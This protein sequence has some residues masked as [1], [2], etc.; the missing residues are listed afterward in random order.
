M[1]PPPTNIVTAVRAELAVPGRYHLMSPRAEHQS[2][3]GRILQWLWDRWSDIFRALTSHIKIGPRGTSL[4]GDLVVVVCVVAIAAI[5]AHLLVQ[6]QYERGRRE[7]AIALAPARSAHALAAAA[8]AAAN[9]GDYTRAIRLTF[10]AAVTLLD[11]RGVMRDERSAT[12]NEL[13][14]RLHERDEELDGPF[15]E[16]A[17][18]YTVAAYAQTPPGSQAWQRARAAYDDLAASAPS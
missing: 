4:I 6:L 13:R 11:L 18:L 14:Q 8:L 1:K 17:R 15:A 7:R 3:A 12:I 10:I 2:L 5:A 16:I 9:A